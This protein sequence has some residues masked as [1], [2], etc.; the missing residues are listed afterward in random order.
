MS[1][2]SHFER[3]NTKTETNLNPLTLKD[4]CQLYWKNVQNAII[5]PYSKMNRDS[6][7]ICHFFKISSPSKVIPA[8]CN[9]LNSSCGYV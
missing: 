2:K 7:L 4:Q 9:K 1:D 6:L 3:D 8:D 5:F